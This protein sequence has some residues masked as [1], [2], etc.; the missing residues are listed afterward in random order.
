LKLGFAA[1]LAPFH[2]HGFGYR[3]PVILAT[4]VVLAIFLLIST[5]PTES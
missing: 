4:P 1:M 5:N 3:L 2:S